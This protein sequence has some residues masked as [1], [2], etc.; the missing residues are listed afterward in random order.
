MKAQRRCL[1]F[2]SF[3]PNMNAHCERVI[4]SIQEEFT[5]RLWF[6]GDTALRHGLAD[7]LDWYHRHRPHQG[8]GNRVIDP[9]PEIGATAG[10]I[11]MRSRMAGTLVHWERVAAL[12][13]GEIHADRHYWTIRLLQRTALSSAPSSRFIPALTC[14]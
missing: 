3:F 10:T 13:D 8:I 2:S 12:N 7:Y 4:R 11:Q 14:P 5:D 6:V 1:S 9:G